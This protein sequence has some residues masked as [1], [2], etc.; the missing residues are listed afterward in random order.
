MMFFNPYSVLPQIVQ[1]SFDDVLAKIDYHQQKRHQYEAAL[2]LITEFATVRLF[3]QKQ[4]S[5]KYFELLHKITQLIDKDFP[6][7]KK[8]NEPTAWSQL[9]TLFEA[10]P[11]IQFE[12][13]A[14]IFLAEKVGHAILSV[15]DI[16]HDL[17]IAL[18]TTRAWCNFLLEKRP[19]RSEKITLVLRENAKATL[20]CYYE[21]DS[22]QWAIIGGVTASV[23]KVI[24]L[25]EKKTE[26]G[27][28]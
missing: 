10:S 1:K 16:E 25:S 12:A 24:E 3:D 27:R 19:V 9:N 17:F 18:T 28:G 22:V 23:F 4:Y 26:V 15:T 20:S 21:F 8:Q 11:A 2:S 14:E 13:D 6:L 5:E 7:P